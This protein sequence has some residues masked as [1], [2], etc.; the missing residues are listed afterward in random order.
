MRNLF[1]RPAAA[2][3]TIAC[4]GDSITNGYGVRRPWRQVMYRELAARR[5]DLPLRVLNCGLD[6]DTLFGGRR[7][8][9]RDVLRYRPQ[10]TTIAFGLNDLA[11][12]APLAEFRDNLEQV[13][14]ELEKI[15]SRPVLMTTVKPAGEGFFPGSP[16]VYNQVIRA[17]AARRQLDLLDLWQQWP[18]GDDPAAF[19]LADGVHPNAAGHEFIGRR[20][21]AFLLPLLPACR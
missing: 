6:G 3:Y 9:A 2:E 4:C 15:A 8:L 14:A 7:R 5:P 21:A 12:G 16:E 13:V 17:V 11:L 18:S 20:A 1:R 10:L 19:F